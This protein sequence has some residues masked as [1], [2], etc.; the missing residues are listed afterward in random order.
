VVERDDVVSWLKRRKGWRHL[1]DRV[2]DLGWVY[3]V[4]AQPDE[5]LDG[6]ADLDR[7]AGPIL[8][9]KRNGGVW[10]LPWSPD[11]VPAIGAPDEA[12]FDRLMW[13]AGRPLNLDL[14]ADWVSGPKQAA[15]AP[16]GVAHVA[17]WLRNTRNWRHVESRVAD[18]GWAFSV[19][20]QP[21]AYHDGNQYAMTYGNGPMMVVK[22]TG[23]WWQLSSM[24]SM[25]PAFDASSEEQFYQVMRDALGS[26][27][28]EH[29]TGWI[30]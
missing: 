11:L 18:L 10:E 5:V 1:D 12:S 6:A 20:T 28:E 14:A 8:V 26:F 24:P 7:T 13:D 27:D 3:L 25:V 9:V 15:T 2:T 30:S 21:D 4:N 23:A 29:P 16:V 19:S 17:A 22:R